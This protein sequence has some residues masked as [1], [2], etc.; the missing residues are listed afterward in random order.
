MATLIDSYSETYQTSG[1]ASNGDVKVG[2]SFTNLA[3]IY[4]ISS[5]K[6]YLQKI[7]SPTGNIYAKL[8]AHDGTYGTS[9]VGT[10]NPLAT[11]VAYD[12][13]TISTSYSL[14]EF[15]FNTSYAMQSSTYYVIVIDMNGVGD[16]DNYVMVGRDTV[17]KLAPGNCCVYSG[18]WLVASYDLIFYIYGNALVVGPANIKTYNTNLLANIKTINTNAI[19]N[20][21]SL[22]TNV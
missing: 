1:R 20:V 13:S 7:G 22:N 14:I 19:S 8:Y 5:C 15:T 11:S 18:S 2:Q 10:G 6:F 21:K 12:V 3:D 4:N 16:G 17:T 9:S